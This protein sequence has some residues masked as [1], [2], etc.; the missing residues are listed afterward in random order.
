[1]RY[2]IY[3]KTMDRQRWL[4]ILKEIEDLY[5]LHDK[6]ISDHTKCREFNSRACRFLDKLEETGYGQLADRMMSILGGCSPKDFSHCDNHQL[7][8]GALERLKETAQGNL[9]Q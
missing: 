8:K 5:E 9:N 7:T 3:Q 1:M 4:E 6:T 2:K